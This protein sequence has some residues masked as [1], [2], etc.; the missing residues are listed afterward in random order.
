METFLN[1]TAQRSDNKKVKQVI[2]N[3]NPTATDAEI[4]EFADEFYNLSENELVN[5]EK[6]E[7]FDLEVE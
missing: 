7:K 6:V 1:L 4:N 5:V 3:I 2:T